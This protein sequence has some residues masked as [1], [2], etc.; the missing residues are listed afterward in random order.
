MCGAASANAFS[1]SRGEV[2]LK[3]GD[4][5]TDD[6]RMGQPDVAG[7]PGRSRRGHPVHQRP[8]ERTR[9]DAHGL[10]SPAI[11]RR[12]DIGRVR[13]VAPRTRRCDRRAPPAGRSLAHPDAPR[14]AFPGSTTAA[15]GPD[16]SVVIGLGEF[17]E[18]RMSLRRLRREP[19]FDHVF[20]NTGKAAAQQVIH[21]VIWSQ[22]RAPP[23]ASTPPRDDFRTSG[24]STP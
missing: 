10:D 23:T 7:L 18:Q 17:G 4:R 20:D 21:R 12:Y 2:V 16:M 14:P 3:S 5:L 15:S 13:P 8:A 1:I 11:L 6:R 9:S 24:S 19:V 22:I